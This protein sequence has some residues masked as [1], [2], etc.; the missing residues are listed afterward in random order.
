LVFIEKFLHFLDKNFAGENLL[1][2]L[3]A[4]S[5]QLEENPLLTDAI[6]IYNNYIVENGPFQ[7]NLSSGVLEETKKL[8]MNYGVAFTDGNVKIVETKSLEGLSSIFDKALAEISSFLQLQQFPN[9][10]ESLRDV[11][12]ELAFESDDIIDAASL[13]S[14]AITKRNL[15]SSSNVSP[16]SSPELRGENLNK[17]SVSKYL[18]TLLGQEREYINLLNQLEVFAKEL[19]RKTSIISRE[20]FDSL[21]KSFDDIRVNQ[22]A[23][24]SKLAD[25]ALANNFFILGETSNLVPS[26]INYCS[27][28]AKAVTALFKSRD[29]NEAF[30]KKTKEF[31]KKTGKTLVYCIEL[32]TIRFD[33]Y[34][35]IASEISN[36]YPN[37]SNALSSIADAKSR[38]KSLLDTVLKSFDRNLLSLAFKFVNVYVDCTEKL[39]LTCTLA[40]AEN[41]L[42]KLKACL[43]HMTTSVLYISVFNKAEDI[44]TCYGKIFIDDNLEAV[45]LSGN[46]MSLTNIFN[47]NNDWVIAFQNNKDFNKFKATITNKLELLR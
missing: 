2:L 31:E 37:F 10:I 1:F 26:Y 28:Y 36:S 14:F 27:N 12:I 42:N 3:E 15:I 19:S 4:R 22:T 13:C 25:A 24:C 35:K 44:Y 7:C 47:K 6:E 11:D 40:S 43:L 18:K 8:I 34:F 46:K 21:F 30:N 41:K 32:P 17:H 29:H 5:F 23:F 45:E 39:E 9:F 16:K 33:E 20:N 38:I